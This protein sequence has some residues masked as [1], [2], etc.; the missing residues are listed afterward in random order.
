MTD[1]YFA[2]EERETEEQCREDRRQAAAR[3][4]PPDDK[5]VASIL[6]LRGLERG[7]DQIRDVPGQVE[8]LPSV[9]SAPMADE[10]GPSS[11]DGAV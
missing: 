5:T 9:P 6:A 3:V 7:D 8:R 11:W 10:D 4:C 2:W 1:D